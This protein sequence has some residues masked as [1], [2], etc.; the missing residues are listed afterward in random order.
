M[1]QEILSFEKLT[2]DK[3]GVAVENYKSERLATD[4]VECVK[5]YENYT[6][7]EWL[8]NAKGYTYVVTYFDNGMYS[9]YCL[10]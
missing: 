8:E 4:D 2:E 6:D 7:E 1:K 9:V 3:K 5:A 10:F